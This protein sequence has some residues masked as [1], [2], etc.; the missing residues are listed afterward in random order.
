MRM[1]VVVPAALVVA[2]VAYLAAKAAEE[3]RPP[4]PVPDPPTPPAAVAPRVAV[5]AREPVEAAVALTTRA[6]IVPPAIEE[7]PFALAGWAEATG[8]TVVAG[9]TF[10]TPRPDHLRGRVE[11][12]VDARQNAAPDG[13]AVM[14]DPGFAPDAEGFA[15]VLRS[16]GPGPFSARGRYRLRAA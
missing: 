10:L 11:L 2:G 1:R 15:L 8:E 14:D 7:G 16:A 3:G 4:V 6:P 13:P 12:V 5:V 9:V